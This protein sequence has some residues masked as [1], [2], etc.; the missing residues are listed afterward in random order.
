[1]DALHEICDFT[2]PRTKRH[3]DL[4]WWPYLLERAYELAG[5]EELARAFHGDGVEINPGYRDH[6]ATIWDHPVT[7]LDPAGVA[8][9]ALALQTISPEVVRAAV[10]SDPEEIEVKLG[11]TA[12]TFDG[13]LAAHLAEQHTVVRDFY[14]KAASR[15]E[16]VVMWWD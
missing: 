6:P 15:D 11:R 3:L 4:D 5:T 1:M 7:G 8:D 13:D 16:A 9:I 10:P 12:R 14:R 2:A